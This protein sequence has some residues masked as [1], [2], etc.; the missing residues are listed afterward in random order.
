MMPIVSPIEL[1]NVG[2]IKLKYSVDD[3]AIKEYNAKNDDFP[4]FKLENIEGSLG[5]GD[6]KYLIGSFRPLTNKFYS[7]TLPIY[8]TDEINEFNNL[9]ITLSG[10]GYHPLN[11]QLPPFNSLYKNMPKSRI[12]NKFENQNIIQKCGISLEELNFGYMGDKPTN[13]TF[14]IYN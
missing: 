12:Y 9:K 2:G 5:P 11:T 7:V 6:V 14:I 3:K 1:K 8:F 10:Y 13:K 4:I